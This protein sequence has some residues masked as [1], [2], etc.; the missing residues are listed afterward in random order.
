MGNLC[1]GVNLCNFFDFSYYLRENPDV[2]EV[3]GVDSV[4]L[5][6]H[7]CRF[8]YIECRRHRFLIYFGV[9]KSFC[10]EAIDDSLKD[11]SKEKKCHCKSFYDDD[12]YDSVFSC[13]LCE[14][15]GFLVSGDILRDFVLLSF[16]DFCSKHEIFEC[17]ER[18][19]VRGFYDI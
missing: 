5:W 2:G 19:L 14:G 9:R 10:H 4:S 11:C 15:D 18:S 16:E 12:I 7:W 13:D 6:D 8:G 3:F 17:Y 1:S